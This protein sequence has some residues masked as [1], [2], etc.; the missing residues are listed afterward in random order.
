MD[1]APWSSLRAVV[2]GYP[3]HCWR[4][5]AGPAI[6]SLSN[7]NFAYRAGRLHNCARWPLLGSTLQ[8]L[9]RKRPT[10]IDYLNGEVVRLGLE[11]GMATPLNAIMVEMVHQV[12]RTGQFWA[13]DAVCAAI[14]E[15]ADSAR[16]AAR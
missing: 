15:R 14:G 1:T 3:H 9:Q 8:S 7:G 10:E 16:A 5:P 2:A 4:L 11:L 13:F 6:G 12:E